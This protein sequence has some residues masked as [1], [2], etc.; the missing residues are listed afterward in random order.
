MKRNSLDTYWLSKCA[1]RPSW[2]RIP[3][4]LNVAPGN[5][6]LVC[7]INAT[8][9]H[10]CDMSYVTQKFRYQFEVQDQEY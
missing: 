2:D 10:Q 1:F 4:V 6:N 9:S 5:D 8:V 3:I 7:E